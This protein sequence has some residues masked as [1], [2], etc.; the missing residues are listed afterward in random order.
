MFSRNGNLLIK[1]FNSFFLPTILM[2]L[3]SSLSVVADGIIVGNMVGADALAAVNLGMPLIQIFAAI[4]VFF[5]LGGSVL[6]AWYMGQHNQNLTN[7]VYTFTCICMVSIGLIL[8]YVGCF[9]ADS[10]AKALCMGNETLLSDTRKYIQPLLI[11]ATPI[12]FIPGIAYFIRTDA[13][14]RLAS[15]LMIS[16]NL[17]NIIYDVVFIKLTGSVYGAG[18]ATIAANV[19]SFIFV[20]IYYSSK[21]RTF[22]FRFN[23]DEI[24]EIFIPTFKAGT[25]GGITVGLIFLKLVCLNSLVLEY[26][27]REGMV[28]FS[29]CLSCLSLAS[30]FISG[31]AQT[32]MPI[33]GV[34]AGSGD[35]QGIR[36]VFKRTL[37]VLGISI[38]V[39]IVFLILFAPGICALFGLQT[40]QDLI[41]GSHALRIYAPSLLGDAFVLLIV[42]YA[43]SIRKNKIAIIA[44]TLQNFVAI[45]AWAYILAKIFDVEGIWYSFALAG[46]TSTLAIISMTRKIEQS[47][48]GKVSGL[49]MLPISD[50][51]EPTY[52]VTINNSIT[53]TVNLSK[54]IFI[55]LVSNGADALVANRASLAVEEMVVNTIKHGTTKGNK[56][57][58]IDVCVKLTQNKIII[59]QR[60]DGRP[61]S[62][63]E[64]VAPD[65][66]PIEYRIKGLTIVKSISERIE[67]SYVTGFNTSTIEIPR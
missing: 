62:P 47:S 38:I 10:V 17:F 45:V 13:H 9:E 8:T 7:S 64:Y 55:F 11:G 54:E 20:I 28:A 30:M 40:E 53:E 58:T 2:S 31:A 23:I 61:F 12:I 6:S 43:Q 14:A 57:S 67:Y 26:A 33:T 48:L 42:Y 50:P 18:L 16:C 41:F 21:L 52:D 3:S 51:N 37:A 60:D 15:V 24:K 4:F 46:L 56:K 66:D 22:K 27:G 35:S 19:S 59:S 44:S 49:L 65:V 39:L 25:P 34:L 36:F 32:M 1:K 63:L 5:G 29:V